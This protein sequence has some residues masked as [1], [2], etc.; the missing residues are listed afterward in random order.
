MVTAKLYIE[1]GG[2]S[3]QNRSKDL[4]IRF[5]EGWTN[6]LKAAG[7]SGHMPKPVRGGGRDQTFDRFAT[8]VADSRPNIVPLLLVDSE[9]PVKA[10]HSVWQH[11]QARDGWNQPEGAGDDQGFLMVQAM[12]TW[13]LAD[14]ASLR[15][16]FGARFLK[17]AIPQWPQLQDVPKATVLDALERATARCRKSYAKG[18][19]SFELLAQVDPACV[20]GACPHAKMLLERLRAM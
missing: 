20:E 12:E 16:C 15:R 6:F 18:R 3:R 8:A 10:G 13:F 5:R 4:E 17:N 19:V 2:D 7:L 9:D 1:G 11:L 14:R